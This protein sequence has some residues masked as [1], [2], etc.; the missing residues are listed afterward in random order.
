[1]NG[2]K[3][4]PGTTCSG[5]MLRVSPLTQTDGVIMFS[6]LVPNLD[7][8]EAGDYIF[9]TATSDD[10]LGIDTSN[11]LWAKGIRRLATISEATDHAEPL[12]RESVPQFEKLGGE[13]VAVERYLSE[14]INFGSQLT[15]LLNADPY[16]ICMSAQSE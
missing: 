1:M 2:V 15:R 8:A 13:F 9:C 4:I 16:T 5:A 10:R 7:I 11:L 6:G 12:R 14:M 3:I